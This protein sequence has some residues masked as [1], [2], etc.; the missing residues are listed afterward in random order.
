VKE[1][2]KKGSDAF[3]EL[4]T[5]CA[6]RLDE[7]KAINTSVLDLREVNS[8]FDVFIITTGNSQNHCRAL[9]RDLM[10]TEANIGLSIR[11]RPDLNSTWIALDYGTIIV[12]IFTEETRGFYNL[13]RLWGD[14][15]I[16][17]YK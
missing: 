2:N 11:N 5:E 6:R 3:V 13:D 14:A 10:K 4:S 15:Q 17:N 8:Y 12:H 1:T 9:A 7:K 16:L